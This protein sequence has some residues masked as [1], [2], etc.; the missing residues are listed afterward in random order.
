MLVDVDFLLASLASFRRDYFQPRE[1]RR[2]RGAEMPSAQ[3]LD[4]TPLRHAGD[5]D[6]AS[7]QSTAGRRI[8]QGWTG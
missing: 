2:Q 4:L 1:G 8:N 6:C 3:Q 5:T 7:S